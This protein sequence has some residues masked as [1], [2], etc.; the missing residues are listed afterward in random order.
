MF[1][2][3]KKTIKLYEGY[4]LLSNKNREMSIET[5]NFSFDLEGPDGNCVCVVTLHY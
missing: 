3:R 2:K 4:Y 1:N 5:G